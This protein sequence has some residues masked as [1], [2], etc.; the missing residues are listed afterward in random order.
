MPGERLYITE[1]VL[2]ILKLEVGILPDAVDSNQRYVWT[3]P[4]SLQDRAVALMESPK[5]HAWLTS[6]HPSALFINGN[7][8]ASSR[9]S[10]LSYICSKLLDSICPMAGG[11][12][13][14]CSSILAQA[15]FCGQE[16]D[17]EDMPGGPISMMRSLLAQLV[18]Q[19]NAFDVSTLK[20]LLD[21][22]SFNVRELCIVWS[23]LIR[24]LPRRYL[25]FSII[26]GITLYE[27]STDQCEAAM[28]AT[29][30]LLDLMETCKT[31]GCVFKILMTAP[32]MSRVLYQVFDEEEIVWMPKKV[33]SHGGLTPAKW[34]A[35]AKVLMEEWLPQ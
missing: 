9:H 29:R 2:A 26:D 20:Q 30:F 34:E 12:R 35:S 22:D 3:L 8:D 32:G 31:Q 21:I 19:Y 18:I 28:E 1:K 14:R 16:A 25:V 15:F 4:L 10:P 7:H 13:P 27:D 5:L 24:Q 33:D 6:T 11:V 23:E 17:T